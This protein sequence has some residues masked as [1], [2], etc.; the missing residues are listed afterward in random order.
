MTETMRKELIHGLERKVGLLR[1]QPCV[2]IFENGTMLV[3]ACD[4]KARGEELTARYSGMTAEEI[5][6]ESEGNFSIPANQIEKIRVDRHTGGGDIETSGGPDR[7][8]LKTLLGKQV[9]VFTGKGTDSA[10]AKEIL[11]RRFGQKVH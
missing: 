7:I 11:A 10:R 8:I 2:V 3:A 1:Y 9:F 5:L 4:K 6:V